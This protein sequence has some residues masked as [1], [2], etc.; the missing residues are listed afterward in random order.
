MT[1]AYQ[2]LERRFARIAAIGDALGILSWDSQTMMPDGSSDGRAEQTATLT[3]LAHEL[4]TDPRVADWLAE[5]E[6]TDRLDDW[7]AANLREMRRTHRHATAVPG[8]LIEATSKAISVC[9]MTWRTARAESDFAKLL[10]SLSE[11][12]RRVRECGEAKAAAMGLSPYNAML[13][14]HD[15]GARSERIDALFA[16]LVGFLPE[17]IG[18]VLDRQAAE[19]AP[20]RPVG[21]FAVANQKALGERLM[22]AA[23]F[24]FTRGRLDVSLHP[25]CG[26]AT[27]DVRITTRYD[28]D[29]FT[30]ALMG[31]MHETGHALYEQGRPRDWLRQPVGLARGMAVHESQSLIVEMQACRSP[32]FLC[33]LAPVARE[34]FGGSGP[35]WEPDNLRRLYSRVERGFIRVDA[36]EVT[37][38]A[39]IILRYRLEK[40]LIAGDLALADLPGAWNDGMRELV[41]VTPPND[42]LGCLQDIH[43]PSGA[44]GYFPSYTLGAMTAAQLFEAAAKAD[45]DIRPALAR[46]DLGPLVAWLGANVHRKGCLY[47]SGDDL[48]TAATGHPL[49]AAVFR[50]HLES[51]YLDA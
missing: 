47:A 30:K 25:F 51:R 41:G 40:A 11:V 32:E 12:L 36:D 5:A 19:P 9:E 14:E 27:G 13:D 8:D 43:W 29:D 22:R 18:R 6:G 17:L 21:P 49:D 33:W 24:D 38:P 10:P 48:L 16:G 2:E 34:A 20:L 4:Q 45:P 39:H 1:A 50:R 28:E 26:G 46:G 35:A 15:P 3:V 37:Y 31:V 23:G 42:R 7:Q 44:W